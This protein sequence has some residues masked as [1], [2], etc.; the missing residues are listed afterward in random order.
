MSKWSNEVILAK[1]RSS[2]DAEE[3]Q[4]MEYL[5]QQLYTKVQGLVLKNSGKE[6]EVADTFQEG[7]IA[8]FK[9]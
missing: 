6:S 5:Y 1:F 9:L 7:L 3:N 8:F 2:N 4:A